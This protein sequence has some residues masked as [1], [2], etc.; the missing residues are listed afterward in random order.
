MKVSKVLT[1]NLGQ[2]QSLR[3]GVDDAPSFSDA[4]SCIISELERLK[5]PVN[6][7]IKQCL[8][9]ESDDVDGG[10]LSAWQ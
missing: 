9:W 8:Q 2:Y 10:G 3:I 1:I 6:S 5:L 7:K 4:D